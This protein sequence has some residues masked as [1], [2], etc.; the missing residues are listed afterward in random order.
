MGIK[1]VPTKKA[2]AIVS[3]KKGKLGK[4]AVSMPMVKQEDQWQAEDDLRTLMRAEDIKRDRARMAKVKAIA[5]KQTAA[6]SKVTK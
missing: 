6:V 4:I 3:A 2:K 5:K 1:V